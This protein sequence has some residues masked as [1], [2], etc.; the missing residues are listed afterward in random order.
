M[1]APDEAALRQ[2][3]RDLEL[4]A[5]SYLMKAFGVADLSFLRRRY[6]SE[7]AE[8]PER[9][10][11][12]V[13]MGLRLPQAVLDEIVD[14]PT[15]LYFHVYRQANYQLDRAAYAI[16]DRL[17]DAGFAAMPVAASQIVAQDPMRGLLSH[18]LIGWAAGLGWWGRNNLLV[19][20]DCGCQMRYVTVLTDAPLEPDQPLEA[21]CGDCLACVP[22]C[23]GGAIKVEREGFDLSRC[24]AKLEEFQKLPYVSQHICGVCLK[25]CSPQAA[26]RAWRGREREGGAG[27]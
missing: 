6:P 19:N 22:Q 13:A 14:H 21:D 23:P 25:A 20:P 8:V 17:Q 27:S 3:K 18:R 10:V 24:R 2:L 16:A 12:G 1:G 9:F 4:L 5:C 26:Q 7:V 11:R 15:P